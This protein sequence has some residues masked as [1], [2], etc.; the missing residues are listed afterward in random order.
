MP[1]LDWLDRDAA[2]RTAAR[3]PTR[4]LRPHTAGHRFGDGSDNLLVQGDNLEALKALL[5]FYRGRV[6]A[7]SAGR[8]VFAML[9]KLER[10]MNVSQ[11]LDVAV[12]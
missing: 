11:Q 2:F 6:A 9:Y 12:R 5:P 1:T 8:A 7:R 4:V 3:V 10:G